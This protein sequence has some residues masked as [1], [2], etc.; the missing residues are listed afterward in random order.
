MPDIDP[1]TAI[2]AGIALLALFLVYRYFK[3]AAQ[4]PAELARAAQMLGLTFKAEEDPILLASLRHYELALFRTD[5]HRLFN[6]LRGNF[7]GREVL[8]FDY[9]QFHMARNRSSMSARQRGH[10][11]FWTTVVCVVLKKCSLPVYRL[12]PEEFHHKI[13][14][15]LGNQDIDFKTSPEFSRK[16]QLQGRDEA[17]IRQVFMPELLK[18]YETKSTIHTEAAGDR[19]IFYRRDRRIKPD[20]VR[21]RLEEASQFAALLELYTEPST[22]D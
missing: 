18:L 11:H 2:L 19:V 1:C 10:E 16:F 8:V 3:H 22:G 6:L 12:F 7:D 15:L 21:K 4:R 5:Q 9:A 17:A 20:E 14:A 13:G